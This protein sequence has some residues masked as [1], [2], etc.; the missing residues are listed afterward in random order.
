MRESRVGVGKGVGFLL[1]FFHM[2]IIDYLPDYLL[3]ILLPGWP[4]QT[5]YLLFVLASFV[6]PS[7]MATKHTP[8]FS[9]NLPLWAIQD[10]L[11]AQTTNPTQM[12]Q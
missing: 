5:D 10:G 12:S 4:P 11:V 1:L 7:G 3:F 2:A 9:P 8:L 6:S